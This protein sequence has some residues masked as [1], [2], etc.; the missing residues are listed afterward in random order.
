MDFLASSGKIRVRV[1]NFPVSSDQRMD[2]PHHKQK[3]KNYKMK[4]EWATAQYFFSMSQNTHKLLEYDILE[5]YARMRQKNA[6][7]S[8]LH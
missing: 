8:L 6:T 4:I 7:S 1:I 3:K 2:S 5:Y